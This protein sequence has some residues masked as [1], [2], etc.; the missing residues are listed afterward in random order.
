MKERDYLE[1]RRVDGSIILNWIVKRQDRRM[2]TGFIR[3]AVVGKIRKVLTFVTQYTSCRTM[4][5]H[6]NTF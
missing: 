4:S 6:K 1:N 3:L 2:E 5:V